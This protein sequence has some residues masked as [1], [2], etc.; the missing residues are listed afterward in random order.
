MLTPLT[1]VSQRG[2]GGPAFARLAHAFKWFIPSQP[3]QCPESFLLGRI[4]QQVAALDRNDF[5]R[6][7]EQRQA[8]RRE[9][10]LGAIQA[11]AFVYPRPVQV[12][13]PVTT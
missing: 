8:E 10:A 11:P 13:V 12:K 7:H 3:A 4:V 9:T 5:V 6:G 1:P 2:E